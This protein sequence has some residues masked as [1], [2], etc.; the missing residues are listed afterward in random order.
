MHAFL[1]DA[2]ISLSVAA[3]IRS[4]HPEIVIHSLRQWPVFSSGKLVILCSRSDKPHKAFV[5]TAVRF[6]ER[7]NV[8]TTYLAVFN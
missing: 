1:T 6:L 3:Q 8:F 5:V 2:H 7:R 4:K